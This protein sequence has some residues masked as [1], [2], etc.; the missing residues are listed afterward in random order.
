MK[1]TWEDL[2]IC[3][4]RFIA[5]R[6]KLPTEMR[7]ETRY[8]LHCYIN[9]VR[10]RVVDSIREEATPLLPS[11]VCKRDR[12]L[13]CDEIR[14]LDQM[15]WLSGPERHAQSYGYTRLSEWLT[16]MYREYETRLYRWARTRSIP[17][18]WKRYLTDLDY[19]EIVK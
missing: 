16:D 12:D 13:T 4:A 3:A 11:A 15:G 17:I 6:L 9:W 7:P 1:R 10:R 19:P 2:H 14:F 8:R 18:R 5:L